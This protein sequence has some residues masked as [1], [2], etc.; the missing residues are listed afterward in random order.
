MKHFK[1]AVCGIISA[2]A[3]TFAVTL[4]TF[5]VSCPAGSLRASANSLAEC[6]VPESSGGSAQADFSQSVGTIVKFIVGIAGVIAVVI[7]IIA[8][9]NIAVSQGDPA[10]L[11]KATKAIIFAAV[12]LVV[13]LL[14]FAIVNFALDGIGGAGAAGGAGGDSST[15]ASSSGGTTGGASGTGS[16]EGADS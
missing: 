9:I 2:L 3:L 15:E 7:I 12:G 16:S 11:A 10:K 4:P 13:C 6:N 14:A 5:A 1:L 8:G